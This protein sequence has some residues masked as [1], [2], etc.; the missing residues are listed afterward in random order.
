MTDGVT[1]KYN[2]N[3]NGHSQIYQF[4]CQIFPFPFSYFFASV[5]VSVNRIKIFPITDI[6]VSVNHTVPR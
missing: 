3:K 1:R 2:G 4:Q 5:F 6:S